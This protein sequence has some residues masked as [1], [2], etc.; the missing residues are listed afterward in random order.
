MADQ[1]DHPL[2]WDGWTEQAACK[3]L[4]TD[5]FF[6]SD[7][8]ALAADHPAL[9]VCRRCTVRDRCLADALKVNRHDDHGVRGGLTPRQRDL[10]RRGRPV[11]RTARHEVLDLLQDGE[12][13]TVPGVHKVLPRLT[14][15]T[16]RQTLNALVR[17]GMLRSEPDPTHTG[18]GSRRVRY[19]IG[20]GPID[21]QAHDAGVG[22]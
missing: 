16:L 15:H 14:E 12:W 11:R 8:G 1:H 18:Y 20:A 19:R 10:L 9:I 5:L 4:P 22:L 17:E 6:P 2:R 3:D 7:Q 13:W 21:L